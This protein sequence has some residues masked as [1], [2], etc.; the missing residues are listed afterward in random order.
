MAASSSTIAWRL[1]SPA[2]ALQLAKLGAVFVF[3]FGGALITVQAGHGLYL[4]MIMAVLSSLGGGIA[5]DLLLRDTP[6]TTLRSPVWLIAAILGGA[7]AFA[8]R[9]QL[10]AIPFWLITTVDAAA[11][12]LFC[13]AGALKVLDH[14]DGVLAAV[15]LGVVSAV[16][17]GI[18][19]DLLLGHVPYVLTSSLYP[20]SAAVGAAA[21]V[22]AV[23]LG[24]GRCLALMIGIVACF[25]LWMLSVWQNWSL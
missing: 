14:R 9:A 8:L 22:A 19:R 13:A 5:R 7:A 20:V 25:A 16:G 24:R 1:A 2:G 10:D 17:G 11:L 4:A 12:A 3:G 21:L 6:P 23:K 18:V 15:V